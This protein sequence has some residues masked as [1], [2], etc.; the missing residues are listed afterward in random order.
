MQPPA[1]SLI[2]SAAKDKLSQCL[3]NFSQLVLNEMY[4]D[5][6]GEFVK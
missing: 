3:N 5:Q 1:S 4:E 2:E 6:L